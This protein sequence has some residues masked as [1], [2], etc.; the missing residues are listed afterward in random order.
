MKLSDIASKLKFLRGK[1]EI[2]PPPEQE[3][4]GNDEDEM[5]EVNQKAEEE[6]SPERDTIEKVRDKITSQG[7]E[8]R[9]MIDYVIDPE[10]RTIKNYL[11][12]KF[13]REKSEE[14]KKLKRKEK[15]DLNVYQ[16]LSNGARPTIEYY[17]LIILSCIIATNGLIMDST[18]VI[19][20]AMIVAPLMT[21]ILAF[22]LG[23]IWGDLKLIKTSIQ[24]IIKGTLL[25]IVISAAI[26]YLVPLPEYSQEILS[27]TKPTLYD[28]IVAIASGIVGAYGYA[29]KKIS[30]TLVGIAIAVALMPPLCTI[31]IG[32]GT[33]SKSITT[34]AVILYVIN[35]ISISLAGAVVFW[36]MKI[37]PALADKEEVTKRAL[38]QIILSIVILTGIAIPLGIYMYERYHMVSALKVSREII[39]TEFADSSIFSMKTKKIKSGYILHVT[40]TG[41]KKP[42]IEKINEM[43]K[44]ILSRSRDIKKI[45]LQF[46]QSSV[47][48]E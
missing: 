28:I 35:L 2:H 30:T 24:S 19:I 4:T 8:M 33:F 12:P 45:K 21:P 37:H 25:A 43:E 13:W 39:E 22:S 23:V 7:H 38:Y 11:R 10:E 16:V 9:D 47:L 34:G 18:A 31:G 41:D 20:G 15:E 6:Q 29:N 46:I 26:A 1:T 36:G 42:E 40:L 3:D 44:R 14:Y 17:I 32:L 5:T 48:I 27:R